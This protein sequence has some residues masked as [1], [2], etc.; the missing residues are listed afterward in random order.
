MSTT[1]FRGL[2]VVLGWVI[3]FGIAALSHAPYR[4]DGESLGLI[5]LTW[6]ARPERIESCRAPAEEELATLPVHMRQQLICTGFS[7]RYR[8]IAIAG[9]DTV[10]DEVIRGSGLR[11]DRPIY[12]LRDVPLPPGRHRL[13]VSFTRID[14][15]TTPRD[16]ETEERKHN[17]AGVGPLVREGRETQERVRSRL[18][19]VP[20]ELLFR[21]EVILAQRQVLVMSYDPDRRQLVMITDPDAQ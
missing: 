8:L 17:E 2:G 20:A 9:G 15:V 7:A 11:H 6:R 19:A 12:L 3:M 1:V 4:A 16:D 13:E 10:L 5:R 14:S 18:D 21:Q